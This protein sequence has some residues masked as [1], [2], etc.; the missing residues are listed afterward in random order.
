M[1]RSRLIVDR[2][3]RDQ[4][5]CDVGWSAEREAEEQHAAAEWS[6]NVLGGQGDEYARSS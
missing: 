3:A 6:G 1:E 4:I 2:E 5:M